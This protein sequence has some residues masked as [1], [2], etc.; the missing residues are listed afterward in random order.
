MLNL[1]IN[2]RKIINDP[3]FGFISINYDLVFDL[4]EHPY[5]QRLRR[6]KQLGLSCLVYPGANHTRFEHT[7]GTMHLMQLALDVLVSKGAE[8]SNQEAEATIIAILLHDIG[9]GPFSHA[10]E[11]TLVAEISHEKISLML[12]KE[13]NKEF[14][15]QLE[16]AIS[17]FKNEYSKKFLHQLV[18]SQLDIDRLDYLRRDSFYSGVVEGAIGSDRI[19][20]MLNVK[21]DQLVIDKKGIY[22]VEK[23]LIA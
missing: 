11:S 7:I 21:N 23:F 2:K 1:P 20:N 6:I 9:H 4:I 19:I 14:N 16:L 22:S 5:F 15:N 12:M 3:V 8:I 18:S 10:L 17:I 13:L